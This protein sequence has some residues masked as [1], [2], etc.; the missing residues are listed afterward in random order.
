MTRRF[1]L[2]DVFGAGPFTGNPLAVIADA[3]G[4]SSDE[5]QRITRWLNLSETT[6]LLPPK[7]IRADYCARIFTL[8]RELPFAGHPTLGTCHAWLEA[9]GTPKSDGRIVQECGVGLVEIHRRGERLAFSAPPLIRSG[10]PTQAEIAEVADLLRLDQT[11]IVDAEWV[12]NG[13]GWIAVMLS[14]ADAVL[15]VDHARYH[16]R[17]IAVGIVGPHPADSEVAFEVRAI[18]SD[19]HGTLIED[20]VCGSLNASV[21]QWIFASGRAADSYLAAQGGCI[22]RD[23]RVNVTQDNDG[24]VWVGGRTIT[25]FEGHCR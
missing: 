2:V 17:P 21:G 13:P 19:A 14:T 24:R 8:N 22:G 3:D 18:F 12:D 15:A 23:G 25:L 6:F 1:K 5:M 11:A 16:H 10:K 4:L 9:G 7:D 20:P